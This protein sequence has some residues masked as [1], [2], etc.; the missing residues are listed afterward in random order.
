MSVKIYDVKYDFDLISKSYLSQSSIN[1][2][3]NIKYTLIIKKV[4]LS[5]FLF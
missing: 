2:K 4:F 5:Y 1:F 3:S